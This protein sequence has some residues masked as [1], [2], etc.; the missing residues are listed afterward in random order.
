M[1]T[2]TETEGTATATLEMPS[3]IEEDFSGISEI[4]A[5]EEKQ[6]AEQKEETKAEPEGEATTEGEE[7]EAEETVS[8]SRAELLRLRDLEARFTE[9]DTPAE[10]KDGETKKEET[11][12]TPPPNF[13]E[14]VKVPFCQAIS[15][16]FSGAFEDALGVD[17]GTT[18]PFLQGVI[19][20][21]ISNSAKYTQEFVPQAFINM[22]P[23]VFKFLGAQAEVVRQMPELETAENLVFKATEKVYKDNPNAS[24]W[25]IAADTVKMLQER[26]PKAE[27]M[28][29][30]NAQKIDAVQGQFGKRNAT[31]GRAPEDSGR[32]NQP[33][34]TLAE[35]NAMMA[36]W[37]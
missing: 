35:I 3:A 33:Q 7:K 31:G 32:N 8:L 6:E 15:P 17:K 16:E 34:A 4:F 22:A 9:D 1:E 19:N 21:S 23:S 27:K 24:Q 10:T 14:E 11:K 20:E 2:V 28:A 26:L 5:N 25:K 18:A 37:E 30:G 36:S 13:N 29:K 12:P